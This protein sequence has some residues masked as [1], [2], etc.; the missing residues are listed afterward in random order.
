[1]WISSGYD[2]TVRSA[3]V[4]GKEKGGKKEKKKLFINAVSGEFL[5]V[6]MSQK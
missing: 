5:R 4:S 1:M 6:L 3:D 2:F